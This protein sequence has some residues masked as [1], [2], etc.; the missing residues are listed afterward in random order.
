MEVEEL[1]EELN[2]ANELQKVSLRA[3]RRQR[4]GPEQDYYYSWFLAAEHRWSILYS[5]LAPFAW[6]YDRQQ[7]RYVA[8]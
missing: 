3:C 6:H 8:G 2:Q 4:P 7:Q 1:L 5:E